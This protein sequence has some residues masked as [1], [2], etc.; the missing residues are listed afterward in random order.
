M[1]S[2]TSVDVFM[3]H[4]EKMSSASGGLAPTP[5]FPPGSCPWTLLGDFRPS[6]PS[7]LTSGKHPAGAHVQAYTLCSI[8]TCQAILTEPLW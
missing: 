3:H 4:Y 7:L 6:D 8:K 2:K 5:R 1:L